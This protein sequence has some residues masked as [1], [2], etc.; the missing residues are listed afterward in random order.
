MLFPLIIHKSI[1]LTFI[2]N[3]TQRKKLNVFIAN[4]FQSMKVGNFKSV[5]NSITFKNSLFNGQGPNH[6]FSPIDGGTIRCTEDKIRLS[7]STKRMA[8]ITSLMSLGFGLLI[9]AISQ[10]L[11]FLLVIPFCFM[12]LYGMNIIIF[13]FRI[14][15]FKKRLG[16]EIQGLTTQKQ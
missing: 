12:W 16:K 14:H 1:S 11:A 7:F 10:K 8:V 4:K 13:L 5:D 3:E 2:A 15:F 6:I 9:L